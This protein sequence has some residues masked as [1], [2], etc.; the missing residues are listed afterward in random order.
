[1][2]TVNGNINILNLHFPCLKN[3]QVIQNTA[4]NIPVKYKTDSKS[5]GLDNSRRKN[6][7]NIPSSL[8][9]SHS[10][11]QRHEMNLFNIKILFYIE[12]NLIQK[13]YIS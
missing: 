13:T 10:P 9:N 2:E 3:S 8:C 1:M 11:Q 4:Y 5:K 7:D 6:S 12:C